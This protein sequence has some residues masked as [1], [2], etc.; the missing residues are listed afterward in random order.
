[1]LLEVYLI[2]TTIVPVH[3]SILGSWQW[4]ASAAIGDV[5]FTSPA[6]AWLGLLIH[7][8]ISISWAGGYA[9]LAQGQRFMN[10]RWYISGPA[11]GIVVYIFMDIFLLGARKL[12]PPSSAPMLLNALI[13]HCVFFGLPVA[14]VV[15][16]MDEHA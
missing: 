15:A 11:Y 13:A 10:A 14:Y 4:I 7:F 16:R 6:Y 9:Y 2:A 8:F 5:A 3:A 1:M 12:G